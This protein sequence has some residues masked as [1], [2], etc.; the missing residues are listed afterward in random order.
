MHLERNSRAP[1]KD[2]DDPTRLSNKRMSLNIDECLVRKHAKN[3]FV[4]F[5]LDLSRPTNVACKHS[6]LKPN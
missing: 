4:D 5:R 2:E 6:Y 3:G 1:L